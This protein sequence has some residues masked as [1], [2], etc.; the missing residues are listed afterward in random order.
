ME[1]NVNFILFE[2]LKEKPDSGGAETRIVVLRDSK[3]MDSALDSTA[4]DFDS[5]E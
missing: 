5:P 3:N 1:I 2:E 4:T